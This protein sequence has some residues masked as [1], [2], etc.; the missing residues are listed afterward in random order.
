MKKKQWPVVF[1]QF[2]KS[3]C[4]K[5]FVLFRFVFCVVVVVVVFFFICIKIL[6]SSMEVKSVRTL[7][8]II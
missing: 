5:C 2:I 8:I 3:I 4:V 7:I 6:I 1:F